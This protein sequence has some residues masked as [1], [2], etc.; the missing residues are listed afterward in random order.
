MCFDIRHGAKRKKLHSSKDAK[1]KLEE[2]ECAENKGHLAT[3][4]MTSFAAVKDAPTSSKR[5]SVFQAW[6]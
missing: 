2:V 5:R 3:I 6:G 1:S 4:Q